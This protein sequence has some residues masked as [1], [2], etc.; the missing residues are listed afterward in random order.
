MKLFFL[1]MD[2]YYLIFIQI[3]T[4]YTNLISSFLKY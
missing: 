4:T 3:E 2:T 1:W